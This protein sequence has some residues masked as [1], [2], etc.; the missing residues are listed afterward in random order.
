MLN[1]GNNEHRLEPRMTLNLV[2]FALLCL[3]VLASPGALAQG[4]KTGTGA[5]TGTG[6]ASTVNVQDVNNV[7]LGDIRNNYFKRYPFAKFS[8]DADQVNNGESQTGGSLQISDPA[9]KQVKVKCDFF[10]DKGS[11]G[12][13]HLHYEQ[14][15]EQVSG[16]TAS[17]RDTAV[18][19]G[20]VSTKGLPISDTMF[21]V[22]DREN[23]QRLLE[24]FFDPERWMWKET[25]MEHMK[26]ASSA[27][28]SGAAAETSFRTSFAVVT[29][30]LI[31]VANERSAVPTSG[32]GGG[33]ESFAQAVY[34]VQQMYRTV[35]VP[36]ALLLLL[37]G[38]ILTQTKG[39]ISRTFFGGDEDSIN[40]FTGI[41][42]ALIAI[43]LIP[44]TQ[45]IVSYAIDVGNALAWEVRDPAKQWIQES[46]LM[47]WASEQT[48]NPPV[49]NVNNAI[50]PPGQGRNAS[51]GGGQQQ[52]EQQ[53]Q[54]D[55]F[56]D[57][58]VTSG[59]AGG[60]RRPDYR[61]LRQNGA[62]A[63]PGPES[64]LMGGSGGGASGGG[65][66]SVSVGV[67]SGGVSVGV[68]GG[69]G[70]G[71]NTGNPV[72]DAILNFL[73]GQQTPQQ[74]GED[75]VPAE[76]K[77]AGQLETQVT[78]EDQLWLSSTMQVGF[79][80]AAHFM[81]DALTILA[82]YQVV[83]MCYLFLLGPIAA[84]FYA[85]PSGVG[86][87]FK[88]VFSNWVDAVV[89][90][91]LWRFWWCVI[92]AVMTQR[93]VYLHPNP[94]SPSEMMV[95]NCFMA[96]LLY[97]PFQPFN[98]HP[99]PIVANVLEKAG[100]GGAGG[101]GGGAA[102]PGGGAATPAAQA[103][104]ATPSATPGQAPGMP[105]QT[106]QP[107][108]APGGG[109]DQGGG[110]ERG[111]GSDG[112]R[113]SGSG[114][115]GGSEGGTGGGGESGEGGPPRARR[116]GEAPPPP[117]V[118]PPPA[119]GPAAAAP[120]SSG[121]APPDAGGVATPA[122]NA[123]VAAVRSEAP[124]AN[125]EAIPRGVAP[126]VA[127]APRGGPRVLV[128]TGNA[129]M[130]RTGI[131]SLRSAAPSPSYL[132]GAGAGLPPRAGTPGQGAGAPPRPAPATGS[133]APGAEPPATTNVHMHINITGSG[134]PQQPPD[135]GSGG[136][137][138]PPP[139]GPPA[140]GSRPPDSPPPPMSNPPSNS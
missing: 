133:G 58:A 66:G 47:Q 13:K 125:V 54:G 63:P 118:A 56:S 79:N 33:N 1:R 80:T 44:S 83:F 73:F 103:P 46:T 131:Q 126:T 35:F 134:A 4:S 55:N 8:N 129:A 19:K 105:A 28:S 127:L 72:F 138:G 24:L 93:I 89:V 77:A 84:A 102:V 106:G 97:I 25:A 124:G 52:Q 62:P 22:I 116:V 5:G 112:S 3:I 67:G 57:Q 136:Q 92:L 86:S 6:A 119:A 41:M 76:G 81:G 104:G 14:N 123:A 100:T 139:S 21:Q 34:V 140:P 107:Q 69:G 7:R 111:E 90:L 53:G 87:L 132:R 64:I 113:E 130:A 101:G 114:Q 115:G 31:N 60:G 70:G 40:P 18:S 78:K 108:G 94:G 109:G 42:R 26:A 135:T 74:T 49:G 36:M 15:Q 137:G 23:R 27:N 48:F 110:P 11:L 39:L 20:W 88:K 2:S 30:T 17:Q 82:G 75:A 98:F 12:K 29:D 51:E 91:A 121:G 95:F 59:L 117:V 16:Q 45:L 71:F 65:G 61:E 9:Y 85:W 50:L 122:Q 38:A 43:F 32:R 37:P 96:L 120:P 68:S 128:N 99:G 10:S